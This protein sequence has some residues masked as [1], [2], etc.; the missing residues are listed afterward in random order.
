MI[1]PLRYIYILSFSLWTI[2][3]CFASSVDPT[4][5]TTINGKIQLPDSL[6]KVEGKDSS[7]PSVVI[8]LNHGEFST[9]STVA[10]GEFSF[11]NVPPGV[12]VLDVHSPEYIFSQVKLQILP[13]SIDEPKCIEYA[14]PGGT[15]HVITE[16]KPITLTAHGRYQYFEPKPTIS[17]FALLKNPM[18]LM[19]IVGAGLMVAM[20]YMMEGLDD[21]Q[22]D[23]MKKQMEAQQDPSK[24]ISSLFG[25]GDAEKSTK[26]NK[27]LKDKGA[28]KKRE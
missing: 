18:V 23:Q 5:T 13:E 10:D 4:T 9:Y 22:K 16:I 24:M 7:L 14:Y 11:Q 26:T 8:T 6:P 27:K 25:T 28:R 21:D 12:H 3:C 19:M 1:A 15:K 20:P 17:V 2:K